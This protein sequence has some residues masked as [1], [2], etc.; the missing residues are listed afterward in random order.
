MKV[1]PLIVFIAFISCGISKRPLPEHICLDHQFQSLPFVFR[2]ID[3]SI[4]IG[5]GSQILEFDGEGKMSGKF[6][7][8]RSL[9]QTGMFIDF[10]PT[11][12]STTPSFYVTID[13]KL[14]KYSS[15]SST[16]VLDK[17][18]EKIAMSSQD[19]IATLFQEYNQKRGAVHNGVRVLSLATNSSFEYPIAADLASY[20]SE[21]VDGNICLLSYTNNFYSLPIDTTASPTRIDLDVDK[22]AKTRFLGRHGKHYVFMWV[23]FDSNTDNILYYD[24]ALKL[25]AEGVI[26]V[27]PRERPLLFSDDELNT[28]LET[29]SGNVYSYDGK[30]D[31]ISV[32]RIGK[33]K[34]CIYPLDQAVRIVKGRI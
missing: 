2:K 12:N 29:T 14:Y 3:N 4:L 6:P 23:D 34:T 1:T 17:F 18:G 22:Y 7:L 31:I 15:N 24:G 25:I 9:K 21:I 11:E 19:F 27:D 33:S 20:N 10:C 30:N 8:P 26:D 32:M 16:K 5:D 13:G 28:Y